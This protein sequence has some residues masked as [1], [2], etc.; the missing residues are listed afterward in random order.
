MFCKELNKRIKK[1]PLPIIA[2][3]LHP[4]L[5]HPLLSPFPLSRLLP[6]PILTRTNILLS[7]SDSVSVLRT[8][9]RKR[10]PP[11]DLLLADF[12]VRK[13]K[14]T[15]LFVRAQTHSLTDKY[16][17]AQTKYARIHINNTRGVQCQRKI[18]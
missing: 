5:F 16:T 4:F 10:P 11:F 3:R 15:Q 17:H 14:V 2:F 9:M 1:S 18:L 13:T 8:H 12:T 7:L 6:P